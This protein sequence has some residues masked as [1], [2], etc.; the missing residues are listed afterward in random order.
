MSITTGVDIIEVSRIKEMIDKYDESFKSKLYTENEIKYCDSSDINK[1]ERYA[2]RFAGKEAV[3]KALDMESDANIEWKDIE[4]LKEE[5]GRPYVNLKNTFND[6]NQKIDNIDISLSHIKET[7]I[8][9]VV[10]KWK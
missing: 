10:V 7:A 4:I 5:T 1:Y 2:A 9:N 3:Y 6:I 8:A